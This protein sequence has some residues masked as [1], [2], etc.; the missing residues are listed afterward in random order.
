M[1]TSMICRFQVDFSG[2]MTVSWWSVTYNEKSESLHEGVFDFGGD[3]IVYQVQ[4]LNAY[5]T[6]W[7]IWGPQKK[8]VD[9]VRPVDGGKWFD[10]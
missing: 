10:L 9:K 3:E 4:P 5:S 8:L 7:V 2:H 6:T 1:E